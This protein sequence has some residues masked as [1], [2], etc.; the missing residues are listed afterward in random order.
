MFLHRA[1]SMNMHLAQCFLAS[2]LPT[3]DFEGQLW[4]RDHETLFTAPAGLLARRTVV[5]SG[6]GL[7]GPGIMV[8]DNA[9]YVTD[10]RCLSTNAPSPPFPI[11]TQGPCSYL[12]AFGGLRICAASP[13]V[14][15]RTCF[16]WDMVCS[17]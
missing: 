12:P 3:A 6:G 11:T 13:T 2:G 16:S 14:T 15:L 8:P 1:G 5:D 9:V 4:I 10:S 17:F 7:R